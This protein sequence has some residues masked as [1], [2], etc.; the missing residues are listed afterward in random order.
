MTSIHY[1]GRYRVVHD[2][3]GSAIVLERGASGATCKA[4][5]I[6]TGAAVALRLIDFEPAAREEAQREAAAVKQLIHINL[7]K[8]YDS[9]LE[10]TRL[11]SALELLDGTTAEEWVT[12]H[13]PMPTGAALRIGLQM[14]NAL[15]AATFHGL[16]RHP[17]NPRDIV[18]VPGQTGEGEWPL[19]K[20]TNFTD[21][22]PTAVSDEAAWKFSSPEQQLG[23]KVDFR[24]QVYSLGSTLWF[25]LT[26]Q[27]AS[28]QGSVRQSN[29]VPKPVAH[30]IAGMLETNPEQRPQDP[31][32]F[33]EEI[34]SCL[35]QV[36]RREAIGRR[37]GLP[38][39]IS[40]PAAVVHE[41]SSPMLLK[42]LA[43][44]AALM[45][46]GGITA[47]L[48]AKGY[49]PM[50]LFAAQGEKPIGVA[51]GVPE[52][53]NRAVSK[54]SPAATAPVAAEI[55]AGDQRMTAASPTSV[56]SE[57]QKLL[58]TTGSGDSPS[59]G[60]PAPAEK[61]PNS[62]VAP[63]EVATADVV[64]PAPASEREAAPPSSSAGASEAENNHQVKTP[65]VAETAAPA[66]ERETEPTRRPVATESELASAEPA[67]STRQES[68]KPSRK[69]ASQ[70]VRR[71]L[72]LDEFASR[73]A[74]PSRS[75]RAR[76]VGTAPDG[77]L[78]FETPSAERVYAAPPAYG[79]G[80]SRRRRV[81]LPVPDDEMPVM[82]AE[83]ADDLP[84]DQ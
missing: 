56:G 57:N 59:A 11:V 79:E 84:A 24:S 36:E 78:M 27:A 4:E 52:N 30:L 6:N 26:G 82:R 64:S 73:P 62:R 12:A 14:V 47:A 49:N 74:L 81:R 22:A 1:L 3:S 76:Y 31:L 68:A 60:A 55:P 17:I 65:A 18:I 34:R 69:L 80:N 70:Q 35:D 77:S 50:H 25:L 39:G 40:A 32:A 19:I 8:V 58:S 21:L 44:A 15:G 5:D 33:Q 83:P 72:P 10:G 42:P 9:G 28:G 46:L 54:P 43:F 61:V 63:P 53:P 23:A 67:R 13:G 20:A 16:I 66:M 2:T 71:A 38:G 7:P 29:G 41:R 45:L 37:F 48:L 51:I 75:K